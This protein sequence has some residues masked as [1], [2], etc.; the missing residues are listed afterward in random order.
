LSILLAVN[1]MTYAREAATLQPH[2]LLR[3]DLRPGPVTAAVDSF[4]I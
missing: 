1:W 3:Y 4:H 2:S